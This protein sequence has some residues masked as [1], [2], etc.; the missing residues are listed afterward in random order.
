MRGPE[1]YPRVVRVN[2]LLRE[3]LAEE[4]ERLS[5]TDER[6]RLLTVTA[7]I[8]EPDLRHATVLFAALEAPADAALAEAR[9]KL[10]AT[11]ASQVRL[12]RTPLLA[13]AADPAVVQG[14]RIEEILRRVARRAGEEPRG[15][16]PGDGAPG[17]G[18]PGGG[19]PGGRRQP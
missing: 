8:A 6:L 5:D 19:G 16:G 15:G 13:F 11:I 12:K 1:R 18:A 4:L 3:V 2:E 17:G 10:Q 14:S 7:V 9:V